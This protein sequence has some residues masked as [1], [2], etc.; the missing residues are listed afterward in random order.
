MNETIMHTK[1]LALLKKSDRVEADNNFDFRAQFRGWLRDYFQNKPSNSTDFH[2][3]DIIGHALLELPMSVEWFL[4]EFQYME[5]TR[6][7]IGTYELNLEP[8]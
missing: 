5:E 6:E 8:L 4:K 3:E 2:K 7:L 1:E